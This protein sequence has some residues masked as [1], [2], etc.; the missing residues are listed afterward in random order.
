[1]NGWGEFSAALVIFLLAHVI[2][3]RPPVR[4]WLVRRF[5]LR[6]YFLGYSVASAVLLIWLFIAAAR[7]PYVAVIPPLGV[8]RWVPLIVM[9]FVCLL[10]VMG[11]NISNP[12]S[13]GGLARRPFDAVN[14][15]I[16]ALTRHPLLLA[17][18]L[19]ALA[20]VL[21]NGDLAH[22][23]LFG[24]LALFAALSMKVI[25][26]R[27]QRQMGAEWHRL[28]QNTGRWSMAALR[29]DLWTG[30]GAVLLFIV[31][32]VLHGPVLGLSPLP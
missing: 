32:L 19:W 16:L 5:G 3:V 17:I 23:I 6:G 2:P 15:G 21:A 27:K 22:I 29:P 18:I 24:L 9:P 10:V 25:D 30:L 26:R 11:L 12:L 20:H 14:P 7:A 13:F 1:M 4:P 31:L 28:A 8:L